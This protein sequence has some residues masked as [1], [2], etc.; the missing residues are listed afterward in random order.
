M[1]T[2]VGY[3]DNEGNIKMRTWTGNESVLDAKALGESFL[4]GLI[5]GAFLGGVGVI[6]Q[7][8]NSPHKAIQEYGNQVSYAINKMQNE[9]KQKA[10]VAGVTEVNFPK[11][12]NFKNATVEQI[13][14]YL[15]QNLD[16]M[17]NLMNNDKV[18]IH[19]TLIP[20]QSELKRQKTV[21]NNEIV[22]VKGHL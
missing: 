22:N 4:G 16:V 6:S 15:T 11:T 9:V 3:V 2:N 18:I 8:A 1:L 20:I 10:N 14:D 19:D 7:I 17:K 5:G 12:I 13:Q 21:I